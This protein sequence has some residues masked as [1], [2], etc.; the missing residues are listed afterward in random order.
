MGVA[1]GYNI[2][3]FNNLNLTGAGTGGRIAVGGT[4]GTRRRV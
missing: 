4:R 3:V 2:F 1:N